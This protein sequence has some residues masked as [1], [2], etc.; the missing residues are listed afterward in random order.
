MRMSLLYPASTH[1]HT[2][3]P[4]PSVHLPILQRGQG[5]D[6]KQTKNKT[7]LPDCSKDTNLEG[8][9]G[10]CQETLSVHLNVQRKVEEVLQ[11]KFG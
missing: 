6:K 11:Y 3:D 8:L 7:A 9:R 2:F 10:F 5:L 4:P 1:T